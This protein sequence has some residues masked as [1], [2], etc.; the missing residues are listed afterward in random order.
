MPPKF[1][2]SEVKEGKTFCCKTLHIK[3]KTRDNWAND[4]SCLSL[5][6]DELLNQ[7]FLVFQF[8]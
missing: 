4:L 8:T 5:F 3:R 1:D 6:I 7:N 2:P